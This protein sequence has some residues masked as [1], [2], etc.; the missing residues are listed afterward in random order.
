MHDLVRGFTDGGP[1]MFVILLAGVL[2]A[3][4]VLTQLG[5]CK[6]IDLMPLLWAGLLGIALMGML[7]TVTGL[8]MA[9]RAVGSA[10][11]EMK[12][13]LMASGASIALYT[14]WFS[15]VLVAIGGFFTGVA[16][17]VVRKF[18]TP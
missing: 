4:V 18:K 9:F 10:P 5:L 2:H 15:L 3:M 8:M 13:S 1:F 17:T 12:Q 14:T 11:P 6:K 16:G 7:G